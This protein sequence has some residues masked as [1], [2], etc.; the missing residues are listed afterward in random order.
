MFEFNQHESTLDADR[1]NK[2]IQVCVALVRE[3]HAKDHKNDQLKRDLRNQ[4][5]VSWDLRSFLSVFLRLD[6][7]TVEY[8]LNAASGFRNADDA[9]SEGETDAWGRKK[10]KNKKNKW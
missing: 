3:A 5:P 7:Q 4:I 1:I 2:W 9:R 6:D 10:K 8:Y